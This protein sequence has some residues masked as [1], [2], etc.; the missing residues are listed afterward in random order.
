MT[1]IPFP[2]SNVHWRTS[3]RLIPSLFPPVSVFDEVTTADELDELIAVESLTNDRLHE[4]IG[5][6]GLVPR[7]ERMLGPGSTPIMAAFTHLN[8][9]GSR[10]SDGTHGVY[11]AAMTEETAIRETVY[12]RERFLAA[13]D[14]EP[15][16][17]V[18][19]MYHVKIVGAFRDL[20]DL[21]MSDPIL[22]PD[23]YAASQ[24]LGAAVR[25]RQENGLVYPSV[26]DP[27]GECVA[28]LK[29]TPLSPAI[30]GGHYGY[31]WDG[32][33]ITHV[34]HLRATGINPH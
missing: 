8:A 34:T 20:R 28:A 30:Q 17:I 12:H 26:R 11:Y 31:N 4:E 3:Y 10:F 24:P 6:L 13:S 19:R 5:D 21:A 23:S 15:M 1:G 33:T 29:T 16:L 2:E 25:G 9:A 7:N 27:G 32:H 22:D 14:T 18:M